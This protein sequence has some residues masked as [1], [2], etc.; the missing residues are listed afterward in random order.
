MEPEVPGSK[1]GA[2]REPSGSTDPVRG[3]AAPSSSPRNRAE[4]LPLGEILAGRYQL[5]EEVGRGALG[6][7]YRALDTATGRQ[8]AVK[9]LRQ[10]GPDDGSI[11]DRLISE[12]TLVRRIK[13]PAV[14]EIHGLKVHEQRPFV[15]MELLEG[16]DLSAYVSSRGGRLALREVVQLL[17]PVAAALDEAHRLGVVHLDL[18][19]ENLRFDRHPSQGGK[20]R[21]LDFGLARLVAGGRTRRESPGSGV[22]TPAYQA[23]ELVAG[24]EPRPGHDVY[25]MAATIYELLSGAPPFMGKALEQRRSREPVPV[26]PIRGIGAAANKVLEAALSVE[27]S[28]RPTSVGAL[29]AELG[30]GW[31]PFVWAAIAVVVAGLAWLGYRMFAGAG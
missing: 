27:P 4:S 13:H 6:L 16:P 28:R 8:V 26:P 14:C 3:R 20:L 25:S 23:P 15:A 31:G 2:T 1:P 30:T 9:F 7:V 5:V 22:G 19:P 21:I 24:A 18:K 17:G 11:L 10:E 29:V 12:V